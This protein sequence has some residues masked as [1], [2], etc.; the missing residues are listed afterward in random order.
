MAAPALTPVPVTFVSSHALRGGAERYLELLM[1]G[2]GA[3][4]V[5]GAVVLQEGPFVDRLRELG[6]PVEVVPT[7]AR[8]G[9]VSG[10]WRLRRVLRR[11]SP[12]VVHANGVKAALVAALA[13]AG[14]RTPVIWVKHDVSFDGPLANAVAAASADVVAVSEAITTGLSERARRKVHVVPNGVPRVGVDSEVGRATVDGL[15]GGRPVVAL[16]GRV[17]PHKGQL[18]L[19]DSAPAVLERVPGARFLL[20]G[21]DDPSQPDYAAAVRARVAELGVSDAV[22][23]AG[24]RTDAIELMS[25]ADVVAVPSHQESFGIAALEAMAVGTPVVATSVGGLPSVVGDCGTLVEPGDHAALAAAIVAALDS[26][27]RERMGECGRRRVAERFRI[28]TTVDAM[29]ERYAAVA[30]D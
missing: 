11:Q 2:L 23:F 22:V 28:E 13:T 29:R 21:G 6:H 20:V 24:D 12:A 9:I 25:G 18:D 4:W 19:V 5:R 17:H 26:D 1:D 10:A 27:A 7:G 14:T 16:V 30:G 8:A 15:A 3:D